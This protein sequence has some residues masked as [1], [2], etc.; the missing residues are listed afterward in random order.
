MSKNPLHRES[1]KYWLQLHRVSVA[2]QIKAELSLL[3]HIYT[4]VY[5]LATPWQPH[6]PC[7]LLIE[8][9]FVLS[10]DLEVAPTTRQGLIKAKIEVL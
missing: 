7:R 4:F 10:L 3:H 5:D 1:S 9:P 8:Q 6:V 2:V